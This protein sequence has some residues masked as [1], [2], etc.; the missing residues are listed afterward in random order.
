MAPAS[1]KAR[2]AAMGTAKLSGFFGAAKKVPSEDAQPQASTEP[3]PTVPASTP[4]STEPSTT[5]TP[6]K[7]GLSEEQKR[8]IE[9]NRQKALERKRAREAAAAGSDSSAAPPAVAAAPEAKPETAVAPKTAAATGPPAEAKEKPAEAKEKP[10]ETKPAAK[11][12]AKSA[13]PKGRAAKAKAAPSPAAPDTTSTETPTKPAVAAGKVV[14]DTPEKIQQQAARR[15]ATPAT[16]A[17]TCKFERL[18]GTAWQQFDKVYSLRL[19]QL[20]DAV[21]TQAKILWGGMVAHEGFAKDLSCYKGASPGSE[22][23]IVGMLF[24]ELKQRMNVIKAYHGNNGLKGIAAENGEAL[25]CLSSEEDTLWLEDGVQRIQ[26]ELSAE[27]LASWATGF[28]VGV[29]GVATEKGTFRVSAI[30]LPKV[31]PDLAPP[32]STSSPPA[33]L[34]LVS[35]LA[36]GASNDLEKAREAAIDFLTGKSEDKDQAALGNAVQQVVVCGGLF[37]RP[38]MMGNDGLKGALQKVDESLLRLA[39]VRSVQVL[40]ARGDPTSSSMPQ[41]PLHRQLFKRL[42]SCSGFRPMSNPA[43]FNAAGLKVVG[44]GGQPVEDLM[45]CAKFENPIDALTTCL[46]A[47]HL[48]PTAPDTLPARP[49]EDEDPFV[50][51]STSQPHVLFS[52]G[53]SKASHRWSNS[54]QC[55]CVPSFFEQPAVVLVNLH[56][57]RDVR[58]QSFGP[59]AEA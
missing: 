41:M 13:A 16:A 20:R 19:K 48:A 12:K 34:A 44:H 45:R 26:L 11:G 50:I 5:P 42:R 54:T 38:S 55:I 17:A 36:Y 14:A 1:K 27:Q 33:F 51:D 9:E 52:G 22:V 47:R 35:G 32:P 7:N 25:S 29:R 30:C 10:T 56:D 46:E 3:A 21:T 39:E 40:P 53:H 23:V 4:P 6:E 8:R 59:T 43:S 58:V 2:T 15:I 28:V 24:K 57:P 37:A 18:P 49:F 31:L